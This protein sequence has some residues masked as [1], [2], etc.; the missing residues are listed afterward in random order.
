MGLILDTNFIIVAEREARRGLTTT[1]DRFF[2]SRADESFFI[3]FTIAGELACGK[4][5]SPRRDWER[6]CRP[7]PVLPWSLEISWVYGELFRHLA[8]RGGLIGT[9][10][11]WIAA[12]ALVHDMGVVTRNTE[13][14][15]RVPNLSV[16]GYEA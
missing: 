7:Y 10:D 13:E 9:N 14:F 1:I 2:A 15:Q 12:T 16:V 11:L 4:S 3:T 6:L 8:A 5:A